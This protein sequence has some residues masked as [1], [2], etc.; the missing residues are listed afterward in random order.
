MA[1]PL[2]ITVTTG[3]VDT[4]IPTG[5]E[6]GAPFVITG[7]DGTRVAFN[8]P[9]DRDYVGMLTEVTGLDA[10]EIRESAD[11]LVQMDGGIHGD[12]YY[13]RRPI[14]LSG[15]LLN[16]VSIDDRNRRMTKM[17]RACRALRADAE[18]TWTL[19][20]GQT[21]FVRV[22][23][24]NGPRFEGAW[25]KTFMVGMVA[26]DPR[27][28]ST[29]FQQT[30]IDALTATGNVANLG[31][32]PTWPYVVIRGP[33]TNPYAMNYTSGEKIQLT[34]AVGTAAIV[35]ID[36]LN[37]T[38]ILD[39]PLAS[40]HDSLYSAVDFFETDWW[41]IHPGD[42]DIRL[43]STSYGSGASLTIQWRDAWM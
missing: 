35:T 17:M 10:P 6:I 23:L 12:F 32:A 21:Q 8:D 33:I 1:H 29:E 31:N 13:G 20:G 42:N 9:D 14:T 22:R 36:T 16:P 39:D 7:P 19:S 18:I 38:V 11:D 25:Q 28:Y 24:Q 15:L 27:I 4:S 34:Y 3:G 37:R 2:T 43:G 40:Y 5:P 41:Q 26:A 30:T